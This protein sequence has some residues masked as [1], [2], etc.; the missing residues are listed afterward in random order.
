MSDLPVVSNIL[1]IEVKEAEVKALTTLAESTKAIAE[2][3]TD[4]GLTQ[5]LQGYSRAQSVGGMLSG[6][7]TNMGRHGLDARTMD[8]NA[9]EIVASIEKVYDK[10]QEKLEA[11][12]KGEVYDD[13]I[14]DP[15]K[16]F[17]DW[18]EEQEKL[19]SSQ[20]PKE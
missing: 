10:Y 20:T 2:F 16:S 18:V 11:K 19:K 13:E 4:G 3:L 12:R 15:E 1:P 7:L 9:L 8:Q 14:K 17:R 6:L 5:V